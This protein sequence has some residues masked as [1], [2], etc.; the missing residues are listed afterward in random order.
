LAG[1]YYFSEPNRVP[2][3]DG[4]GVTS[5][6]AMGH[7][8]YA[9]CAESNELYAWGMGDNYVLGTRDDENEFQP[10]LVHPQQFLKNRV[11]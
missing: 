6:R 8:C 3:L 5:V 11:R 9:L 1:I 7:Y 10:K 2:S 4:K